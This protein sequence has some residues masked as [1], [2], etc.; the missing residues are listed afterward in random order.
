MKL[1]EEKNFLEN[2][3]QYFQIVISG[4]VAETGSVYIK[5]VDLDLDPQIGAFLHFYAV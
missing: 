3:K 5:S 4:E 1:C 2:C